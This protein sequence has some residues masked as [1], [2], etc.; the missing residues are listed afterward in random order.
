MTVF[1]LRSCVARQWSPQIGDPELTG[2]VTVLAYAVAA[3]LSGLVWRRLA[4][5]PLRIFW[6]VLVVLLA[7]LAVNKQLDL[8]T[9]LT[10]A[11]KCLSRAQGWYDDRRVVQVA[12][13]GT[14]LIV[15]LMAMGILLAVLRGRLA[16]NALA[17]TGLILVLGFVMVRAVSIHLVDQLIGSSSLGISNNFLFENAGLVLISVNAVLLLRHARN[18]SR[19][20]PT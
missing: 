11:G 18:G 10:E 2:W 3:L 5:D 19:V 7:F 4:D 9:V 8:Q 1:E 17:M 12:F 13:I 16:Q 20:R 15:L 6:G 14:L